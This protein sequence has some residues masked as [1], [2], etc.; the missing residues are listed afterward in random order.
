MLRLQSDMVFLGSCAAL[1]SMRHITH[2]ELHGAATYMQ[3]A[4]MLQ[5][6]AALPPC[7]LTQLG[8][9]ASAA[10]AATAAHAQQPCSTSAAEGVVSAHGVWPGLVSLHVDNLQLADA[11]VQGVARLASLKTLLVSGP[12]LLAAQQ[13]Q[14]MDMF[15]GGAPAAPVHQQHHQQ[16][17]HGASATSW[18]A[19]LAAA[20]AAGLTESPDP[21][22]M[23]AQQRSKLKPY[24]SEG[25]AAT[26]ADAEAL[27][28]LFK[29]LKPPMGSSSS[30][31]STSTKSSSLSVTAT[32][33]TTTSSRSSSGSSRSSAAALLN[34]SGMR[35]QLQPPMANA[36]AAMQQQQQPGTLLYP[37]LDVD[38]LTRLS[39]L[40]QLSKFEL[41]L[42]QQPPYGK[43]SPMP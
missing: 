35:P 23:S 13:Q 27:A 36:L 5:P 21:S 4:L 25:P 2:I 24:S 29:A 30:S 39:P 34:A 9:N 1:R 16:Q 11:F 19:L 26:A 28:A 18:D 20:A 31:T 22:N 14:H 7:W 15:A 43:H 40:T 8:H 12:C 38:V 3:P 10:A 32:T 17:Q 42:P 41:H 37:V 33:A 6:Q